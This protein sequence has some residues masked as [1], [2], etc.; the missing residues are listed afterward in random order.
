MIRYLFGSND[1]TTSLI[2]EPTIDYNNTLYSQTSRVSAREP[3]PD[4]PRRRWNMGRENETLDSRIGT[5]NEGIRGTESSRGRANIIDF[6]DDELDSDQE[7]TRDY[8]ILVDN[9]T[10]PSKKLVDSEFSLPSNYPGKFNM[11][12]TRNG[13]IDLFKSMNNKPNSIE[14]LYDV[15]INQEMDKLQQEINREINSKK[16]QPKKLRINSVLVKIR[17]QNEF[18][19]YLNQLVDINHSENQVPSNLLQKFNEL[20]KDY[21][22]ELKGSQALYQGYYKLIL[23]YRNLRKKPTSN[24]NKSAF[25]IKEKIRLIKSKTTQ[26]QIKLIC[27]NILHEIEQLENKDATITRLQN[28]LD[29]AN[30]KI[31]LLELHPKGS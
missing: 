6:S 26:E 22:N 25:S 14:N 31:R 18:L 17:E 9:F 30:Q 16:Y 12:H 8:N 24:T 23:K 4:L 10:R 2:N 7:L 5:A 3:S 28:E 29:A 27:S 11:K 19:E 20:K 15:K 1:D 13:S 21:I